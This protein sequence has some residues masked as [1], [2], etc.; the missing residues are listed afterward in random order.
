MT[1]LFKFFNTNPG[2]NMTVDG[3]WVCICEN[4]KPSLACH[5]CDVFSDLECGQQVFG[6]AVI[7]RSPSRL[8]TPRVYLTFEKVT[9]DRS[10]GI[11]RWQRRTPAKSTELAVLTLWE[12]VSCVRCR[13]RRMTRHTVTSVMMVQCHA[14]AQQSASRNEVWFGESARPGKSSHLS[15]FESGNFLYCSCGHN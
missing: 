5:S 15:Y 12:A 10:R 13:H 4:V 7:W 6:D 14:V 11:C 8:S 3:F 9:V 1:R 2:W